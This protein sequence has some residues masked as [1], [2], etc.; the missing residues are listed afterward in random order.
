MRG[1]NSAI[2]R[3]LPIMLPPLTEQNRIVGILDETFAGI[4][5][6]KANA[7]KNLQNARA[8]FASH[9]QSVFTQRGNGWAEKTLGESCE[10][11][12]SKRVPITRNKRTAGKYPYYGASGIVDHVSDYIFDEDLL[13]VS[14][15]GANLLARTYPIAFS[16]SGK[17]WV[18][19]HA[20][21]LRFADLATQRFME[22]Y[23]NLIKLNSYVS[24]MA[25]PKLNQNSL[26]SIPVPVPPLPQR[27][28][29]VQK[30]EALS[31]ETQRL[32]S[33]Y[34]RK[35]IAL[36]ALKKSLLHQ[37]FDGEL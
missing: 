23:L 31:K 12:D 32:E 13:L 35:L 22:L 18:N 6:A 37:A 21:V 27:K 4:A 3:S 15:D 1:L 30:L 10:N 7:E 36:E 25:Q 9:L 26:N 5:M 28:A 33:I 17:V 20:H 8:L 29:I 2:V 14:E 16:V 11:L 34:Q 19:N 24:G